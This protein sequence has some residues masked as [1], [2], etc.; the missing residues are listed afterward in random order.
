MIMGF[1]LPFI[2]TFVAI[3]F[4]SFVSSLRTVLG[5]MASWLLRVLAFILRLC[6]NLGFYVGRLISNLYDLII[7][8]ALWLENIILRKIG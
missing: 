2:L 3:P 7:F 8:P 5:V 1:I 6:G 4:E